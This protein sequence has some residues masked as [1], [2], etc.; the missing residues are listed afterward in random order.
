MRDDEYRRVFESEDS[1]WWYV[2]I[3]SL[4]EN[5]LRKYVGKS[6]PVMLDAGCGTGGNLV[7]L[8]KYGQA[9][10]IDLSPNALDFCRTS[11]GIANLSRGTLERLPFRSDTFDAAISIDVIYHRWITHDEEALS[12]LRRVLKPGGI[13][14]LQSAAF[15]WLRGQHDE[16]VF[17]RKRYTRSEVRSI[18]KKAGFRVETA[19]YRNTLLFPVVFLVR[20]LQ[21][22]G[23]ETASDVKMPSPFVNSVLKFVMRIEYFFLK[24]VRFPIGSSIYAIAI[25]ESA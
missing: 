12:E 16:V 11:R 4:I 10:G 15:E 2:G 18:L 19:T 21:R 24:F 3:H 13:L 23:E 7:M 14:I 9:V 1:F 5:S 17:T 25:K 20:L 8:G 6:K 22:K